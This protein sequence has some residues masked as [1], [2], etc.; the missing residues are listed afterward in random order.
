MVCL[1]CARLIG[2]S[3]CERCRRS[4]RPAPDRFLEGVGLVRSAYLHEGT[5]RRLVHLLKYRGVVAAAAL[6]AEGIAPLVPAGAVLVPL[7]RV[8]ARRLRYGVDPASE[9]ARRV[10][11]VTGAPVW[12]GMIAPVWGRR[13]AGRHHR[14]VLRFRSWSPA[15]PRALLVDDVVTSGATLMAAAKAV[16]GVV[17][18]LTATAPVGQRGPAATTG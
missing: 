17:G 10:A 4:L 1:G 13:R 3:L 7:P 12:E 8:G 15:P 9:L 16:P 2:G 6:L 14:E 11:A 18:A 5:A